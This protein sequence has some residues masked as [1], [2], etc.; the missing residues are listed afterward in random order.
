MSD[1]DELFGPETPLTA[2]A[3]DLVEATDGL[4]RALRTQREAAGLTVEDVAERL[5]TSVEAV[6]EFERV[7]DSGV[8]RLQKVRLYALAVGARVTITVLPA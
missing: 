6:Q 4:I 5:G 8:Q 3:I 1:L 2:L 7:S